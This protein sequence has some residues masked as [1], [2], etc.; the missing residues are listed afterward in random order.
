MDDDVELM[1]GGPGVWEVYGRQE[2]RRWEPGV[3]GAGGGKFRHFSFDLFC[4]VVST[5]FFLLL[6]YYS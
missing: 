5:G 3:R 1:C 2:K 6:D 4:I